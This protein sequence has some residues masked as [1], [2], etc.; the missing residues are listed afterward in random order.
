MR[1][2]R[3]RSAADGAALLAVVDAPDAPAKPR[4]L[5]AVAVLRRVWARHYTRDPAAEEESDGG[6]A[7]DR[8]AGAPRLRTKGELR[9]APRADESPYDADLGYQNKSSTRGLWQPSGCGLPAGS[10]GAIRAHR[11]SGVRQ[12]RRTRVAARDLGIRPP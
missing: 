7:G 9:R 8:R 11:A 4:A 10:S 3:F 5:P 12:L 6:D 2:Q 1:R